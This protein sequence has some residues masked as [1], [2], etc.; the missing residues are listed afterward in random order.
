MAKI[1]HYV[2]QPAGRDRITKNIDL[3]SVPEMPQRPLD[4]DITDLLPFNFQPQAASA[5]D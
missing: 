5:I 2:N 3:F 4:A 1:L